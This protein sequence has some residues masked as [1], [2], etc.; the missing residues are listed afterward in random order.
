MS[1]LAENILTIRGKMTQGDF[2]KLIDANKNKVYTYEKLTN[3]SVPRKHTLQKIADYA[4]IKIDDLLN[5]K[6]TLSDLA[7]QT[8][9]N[10]IKDAS[11]NI[12]EELIAIKAQLKVLFLKVV[13][14]ETKEPGDF[15]VNEPGHTYKRKSSTAANLELADL[16]KRET[17][18]M[19]D[20]L[21]VS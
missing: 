9:K 11:S 4:G 1:V 14:L 17:K 18:R 19:M 20:E 13:E 16:I 5:K 10:D 3:P 7:F 15:S 21:R 2:G 8:N 6:L 12:Y